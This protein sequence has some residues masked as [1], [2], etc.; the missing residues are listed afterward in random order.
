MYQCLFL[1]PSGNVPYNHF[2]AYAYRQQEGFPL[3]VLVG[4]LVCVCE[5]VGGWKRDPQVQFTK[6]Y[7]LLVSLPHCR[8]RAISGISYHV[9][10]VLVHV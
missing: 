10:Y 5:K 1:I 6:M 7:P 8:G 9:H 4:M 2:T 3:L